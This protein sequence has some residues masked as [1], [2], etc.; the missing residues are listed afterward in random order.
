[1]EMLADPQVWLAFATLTALEIVLGIDNIIFISILVGRLPKHQQAK[2][3]TIGLALAM[4][5]RI[6]LLLSIT[7][8]MGLSSDL[9]TVL[10]EG[11][12]GR[13]LILIGGGLFLL[14]K[15]TL[16]IHHSLEGGGHE[17]REIK[18]TATFGSVVAQIAIIDIVFSLDSVITAVGM[19]DHVE[20]MIAA[21]VIAVVVMM[22][23]AGP[24]SDFVDRNPTIKMLALSFLILIGVALVGEGL[25]FHIPKGYVYFAM[26]FSVAVEMLNLRMRKR[27]ELPRQPVKL[28]RKIE[29]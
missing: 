22:F 23:M 4:L 18:G 7:W 6:M 14:A 19:A 3:R 13:D 11:I 29:D 28:H 26:A 20:V 8:V 24:I 27:M 12:S 15:S 25:E 17:Q 21:V 10:G 5:T 1:M 2:G 16:E 9:F